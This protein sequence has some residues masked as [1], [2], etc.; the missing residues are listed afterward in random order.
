MNDFRGAPRLKEIYD[1]VASDLQ[2]VSS[3]GM[4]ICLAGT[5]GCGKTMT[6]TNIIK[7]ASI[8]GFLCLYTTLSDIVSILLS[9]EIDDKYI[10]RKELINVDYLVID[11][12]DTRFMASE[13]A[14]DLFGRTVEG[15]F[16]TRSQNRL[17]TF[18][19]TNSPNI[20]EAFQGSIKD[21]LSSL[22][23]GYVKNVIVIGDDFR[24][25]GKKG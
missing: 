9:N 12:F 15:V 16:R 13:Q 4:S 10:A 23:K 2:G 8:K 3:K 25:I 1:S 24:K 5:H 6:V 11:E 17:P 22:M 20:S 14:S 21:S 7:I 19:C 18:F